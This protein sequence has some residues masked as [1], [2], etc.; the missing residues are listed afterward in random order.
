MIKRNLSTL[1]RYDQFVIQKN[2][3]G[4]THAESLIQPSL[5]GNSLNWVL[6]HIVATRNSTLRLLGQEPIWSD[7]RAA[8]YQRGSDPGS[9]GWKPLSLETIVD[10]LQISHDRIRAGIEM[11]PDEALAAKESEESEETHG[12]S[13]IGLAFHESYHAGQLGVLRRV[14][15]KDGAIR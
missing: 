9:G 4:L 6:G 8:P 7:E 3:E 14:A 11:I 10:D 1:L 12:D 2:I 13:L 5:G 15:G